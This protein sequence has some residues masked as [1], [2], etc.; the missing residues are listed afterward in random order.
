M[1]F[2]WTAQLK[3]S[4]LITEETISN[5]D[6]VLAAEKADQLIMLHLSNGNHNYAVD[7]TT[8]LFYIDDICLNLAP[9][10]V[11]KTGFR[12]IYFKRKRQEIG[13]QAKGDPTIHAYL[14]GWQITL[15]GKN[16][17]RI[18]FIH[19]WENGQVI[20]EFRDKR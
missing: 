18:M 8:G 1:P 19:P 6:K 2:Q 12:V 16:Y 4:T 5:F 11:G 15:D 7:L 9:Q 20:L 13:F 10:L 14:L 3:D 17:Q